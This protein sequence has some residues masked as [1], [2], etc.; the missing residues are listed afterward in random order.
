M[1]SPLDHAAEFRRCL[2]TLDVAGVRRLWQY[3]SPHLPQPTTRDE[4]LYTMHLARAGMKTLPEA[5]IAYSERWLAERKTGQIVT[6]VGISVI[7]PKRRQVQAG[8]MREAMSDAVM[9]A[10]REGVDLDTEAH[11]VKRRM[12]IAKEKA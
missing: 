3:V 7:A 2:E 8:Y 4:T 10:L 6:A 5:L 12:M 11:E 1:L 9:T